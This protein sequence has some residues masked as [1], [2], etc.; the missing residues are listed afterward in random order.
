MYELPEI[1][2]ISF[3]SPEADATMML[4][5]QRAVGTIDTVC[6]GESLEIQNAHTYG[7]R[8]NTSSGVAPRLGVLR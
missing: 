2:S 7:F 3:D 4:L 8:P 5:F 6:G 1:Y